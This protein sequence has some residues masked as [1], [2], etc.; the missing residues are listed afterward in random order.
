ME[1]TLK[2]EGFFQFRTLQEGNTGGGI[3]LPRGRN[4]GVIMVV[5]M[6]T[7]GEHIKNRETING[8][9]VTHS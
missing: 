1:R 3:G 7:A 5:I 2:E 4:I 9:T 6:D 8:D